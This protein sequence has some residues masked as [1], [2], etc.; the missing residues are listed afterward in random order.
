MKAAPAIALAIALV[1]PSASRAAWYVERSVDPMNDFT[2]CKVKNDDY[3][4]PDIYALV[5]NGKLSFSVVGGESYPGKAKSIRVDANP[6][7]TFKE[8]LLGED[9]MKLLAQL[10][11]GSVVRTRFTHWPDMAAVDSEGPIEDFGTKVR[12][13][14]TVADAPQK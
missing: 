3:T 1:L 9:A 11:A 14:L 4:A 7:F 13:C 2:S 5:L 10:E 8:S 6:A 12:S